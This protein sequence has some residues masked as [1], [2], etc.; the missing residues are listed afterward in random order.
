MVDPAELIPS[1]DAAALLSVRPQTMSYWR[2]TKQGPDF[3]R[4]GRRIFYR[5][6]DLML[7]IAAQRNVKRGDDAG[8]VA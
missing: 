8:R 7:W 5:K 4:I 2:C 6:A 1:E 3:Y